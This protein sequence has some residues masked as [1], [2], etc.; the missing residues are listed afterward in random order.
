MIFLNFLDLMHVL[1]VRNTLFHLEGSVGKLQLLI[2]G[3]FEQ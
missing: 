2:L 1:I 3:T